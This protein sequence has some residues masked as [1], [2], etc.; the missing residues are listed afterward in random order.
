MFS[1]RCEL[2]FEILCIWTQGFRGCAMTEA[3]SRRPFPAVAQVLSRAITCEI[4]GVQIDSDRF[5]SQ[6]LHFPPSLSVHHC[7]AVVLVT[8][9]F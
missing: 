2:N 3:V 1:M 6:Y 9:T 8:L 5:F 4:F 7:F